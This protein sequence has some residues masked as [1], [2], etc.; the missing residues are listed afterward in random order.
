MRLRNLRYYY[1]DVVVSCD[2]RDL[3]AH[4]LIQYP[5]LI[6]EVLSPGTALKDRGEKF[7]HY[8][9]ISTLK[10]YVLVDSEQISV[11][12]YRR[13]EGRMWLYTPHTVGDRLVLESIEWEGAIED[14]YEGVQ[15]FSD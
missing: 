10:E 11:E 8:R 2:P 14:L 3:N 4:K 9:G 5:K 1:P 15:F 7:T 13:G 12:C 6:V